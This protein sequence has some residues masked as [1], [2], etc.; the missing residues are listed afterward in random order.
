MV[1]QIIYHYRI[2]AGGSNDN[3]AWKA[4]KLG[5]EVVILMNLMKNFKYL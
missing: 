5:L 2:Y 4:Y 3:R 1:A